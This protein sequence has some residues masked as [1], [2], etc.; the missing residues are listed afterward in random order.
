MEAMLFV[1]SENVRI[2]VEEK[3]GVCHL[4]MRE[5]Q[6]LFINPKDQGDRVWN[7]EALSTGAS[8]P[9]S[10]NLSACALFTYDSFG[11]A[12][13]WYSSELGPMVSLCLRSDLQEFL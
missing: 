1:G 3:K 8:Q 12:E 9:F 6:A 5:R 10:R 7:L 2:T 4:R 11:L 13:K